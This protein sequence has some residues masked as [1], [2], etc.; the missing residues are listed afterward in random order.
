LVVIEY[1]HQCMH[2]QVEFTQRHALTGER[3]IAGYSCGHPKCNQKYLTMIHKD[4]LPCNTTDRFPRCCPL[5]PAEF[6]KY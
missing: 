3:N 5:V 2:R 4:F 1:P 6:L